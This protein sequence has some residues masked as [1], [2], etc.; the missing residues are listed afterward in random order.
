M[1]QIDP[2]LLE[3]IRKALVNIRKLSRET[4]PEQLVYQ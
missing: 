4:E 2:A 1:R 3:V